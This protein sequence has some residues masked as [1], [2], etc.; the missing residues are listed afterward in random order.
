MSFTPGM[1]CERLLDG[2]GFR[3]KVVYVNDDG[4][5]KLEFDD[6]FVEDEVP[7]EEVQ[8]VSGDTAS[9][10]VPDEQEAGSAQVVEVVATIAK[11]EDSNASKAGPQS[12]VECL[13][14]GTIIDLVAALFLSDVGSVCDDQ[15]LVPVV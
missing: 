8:T 10:L 7:P 12:C 11:P 15:L 13:A 5:L 4:S 2:M 3:C 14:S 6:G 1:T 9:A